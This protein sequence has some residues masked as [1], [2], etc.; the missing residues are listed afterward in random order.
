[1]ATFTQERRRL[2]IKTPL[3]KDALLLTA[4]EGREELGRLFHYE[5]QLLADKSTYKAQDLVGQRVTFWV[6]LADG[7]PRYFDGFVKRFMY[8]GGDE[9][10]L[11][12]AEVVPWLW[13]LT[14][15]T[16][17]RIFQNKSVPDIIQQ[18]FKDLG[19]SD[20]KLQLKGSFE[21]WD[22]CVQYRETDFNFVSRLMEEE[23]IFYYFK[24]ED[25]KHTMMLCNDKSAYSP[26]KEFEVEFRGELNSPDGKNHITRW[27]H[28]YEF[29]S[30]KFAQTDYNFETPSTSLMTNAN[31]LVSLN[32]NSKFEL[33]DFPGEYEKKSEGTDGTKVHMEEEEASHDIANGDST[34]RSFMPAGKFKLVKH[35]SKA[36]EG[37]TYV[38][39]SI[40]HSCSTSSYVSGS[41]PTGGDYTNSF[42]C[43]PEAVL[44]RPARS[45]PKPLIHGSQ[46]AV[47]TG[48]GGEEIYPDKYG[49]VKVQF[50]WDR[51]GQK[52]DKSSCWIR[53]STPWSGKNWGMVAIPRIGQEVVVSYL[54]GDPDRPLI[55]GMV[56]NSETMPPYSLPDNKTQS[57][58]KTRSSKGGGG[59]NYNE[60][61]FED[62]MGSEELRFHAE[63][64]QA[65]H[66]ENDRN[67]YVGHDRN[68][69]VD[70]DKS[71]KVTRHKSIKIGDSHTETIGTNMSI[72]VG[73]NLAETVAI[74][75]SE[76]VGAAMELSVGA[77]LAI[78]V[79]AVMSETV[80][81]NKTETVGGSKSETIGGSRTQSI[82]KDA[83]E[84]V[85]G[86]QTVS[87]AKDLKETVAGKQFTTVTKECSLKAK[88]V[89]V[90]ADDEISFKTGSAQITMKK[91]GDITIKG[92]KITVNGS[93]DV[94]IKGSKITE[95]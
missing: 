54:E 49:R 73:S 39:T 83:K 89:V 87:I 74:N 22:Y 12:R 3:G 84:T 68:L 71:E 93:G 32:G 60:I 92:K 25:G 95:N 51:E 2:A 77:M 17:C 15:T 14:K 57:G 85:A 27:E 4:F 48:P 36:E 63:K 41:A 37:K 61:R 90:T 1:M 79:G 67:E 82:G 18:I 75:Y 29:R 19:F 94:V 46:T 24:H 11:Y 20:F 66:V 70:H 5:L 31:S 23:G 55:T 52:D 16:D 59:A 88:K 53:V 26:C 62:K 80:G 64:D 47:V 10:S 69:V 21:P 72:D 6:D 86:N 58:I 56:Y 76:T 38:I 44:F 42:T 34:C 8:T 28:Q 35:K 43:I 65:I 81:A 40:Q 78:T 91:N 45:T 7:A 30:G 9:L 13:F 50:H 33:Y